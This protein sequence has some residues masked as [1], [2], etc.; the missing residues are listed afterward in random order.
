MQN[1][2]YGHLQSNADRCFRFWRGLAFGSLNR[3][4]QDAARHR[5]PVLRVVRHIF[6]GGVPADDFVLQLA[7]FGILW[8]C[9][10]SF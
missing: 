8:I 3:R 5:R 1:S 4:V 6:A 9:V 2:P 7:A 10:P